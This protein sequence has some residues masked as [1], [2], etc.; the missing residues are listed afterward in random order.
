[1]RRVRYLR[2]DEQEEAVRS[3]EW[4][5]LQAQSLLDDHCNWKWVLISLHNATQGFMVLALWKGNGLL[6][7]NAKTAKQ[8]LQ[9]HAEKIPYPEDK[10]D[11]F[12]NLYDKIKD[13]KNLE[14]VPVRLQ[15]IRHVE[16]NWR[17][18]WG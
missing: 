1:M 6:T 8:W 15:D 7:L 3:L 10:L 14:R 5:A 18:R 9:A 4:A 13:K 12:L 2:T 11:N 16:S 17:I